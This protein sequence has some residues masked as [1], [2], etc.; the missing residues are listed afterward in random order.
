M[1]SMRLN[2]LYMPLFRILITCSFVL[3]VCSCESDKPE[4]PD[5]G[6]EKLSP[7]FPEFITPAED[8][9]E[10]RIDGIPGINGNTYQL[11]VSG[12]VD[13]PAGFSLEDLTNLELVEKTLTIECIGNPA[14]GNLVGTAA[15]KGFRVFDL[16]ESLGIDEKATTVKYTCA[17]GYYTYNSI[18]E[19]KNSGVIGA[20]YMNGEP[21][22]PKH[23]YPLRIIFPGYYGVRQ[24][25]WVVEMEVLDSDVVDFWTQT[26]WDT[27][28]SMNVDSK[29]FFPGYHSAVY[30]GDTLKIGGSAFGSRR[31]GSV[32]ITIDDGNTWI[33]ARVVKSMDEDF[34][35]IFWE[36]DFIPD[37]PG[38]YTLRS[39]ATS[40]DGR[41]QPRT[42]NKSLDG[43]DSQPSITI[44]VVETG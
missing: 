8:Y 16:L 32:D 9:F 18:E 4:H 15:W 5:P 40:Q 12:A 38:N 27:D 30:L 23:G 2:K 14:N 20:L 11:T 6:E 34:V 35:W 43:K 24:P 36:Y 3:P 28:S 1:K 26:G 42:D 29:I 13:H 10:T 22:P 44:L 7:E 39:R 17:D 37:L 33:P 25:G 19:L 21:V 31:I 41:I